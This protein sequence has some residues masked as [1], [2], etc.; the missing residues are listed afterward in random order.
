M[1]ALM[2]VLYAIVFFPSWLIGVYEAFARRVAPRFEEPGRRALT[3]FAAGLSVLRSPV[4]FA[5]VLFWA[6][7]HWL[8][9]GLAFWLGFLAVG[10]QVP[11]GAALFLQ[12]VIA[13]G[14]ALPAAPG[15]FGVF[16]FFGVLGLGLYGVPKSQAAAWAIGYHVV[17][18]LPIT[19][20]GAWYFARMGLH[21][22]DVKAAEV[23][24]PE[25]T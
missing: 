6:T 21:L 11:F 10:I 20:I 16:E 15:F 22:K 1:L 19:L 25:A 13:L 14:V 23:P 5:S 4:R 8:C 18:F 3:H 7:L 12:G 9:N 24:S 17:S 2:T